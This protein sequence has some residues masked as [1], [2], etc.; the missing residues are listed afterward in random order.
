MSSLRQAIRALRASPF[1]STMVI[2]SLA[3]GIGANVA[4]FSIVDA[5]ILRDLPV[6]HAGRLAML[7]DDVGGAGF[8]SH[9]IWESIQRRPYLFDGAFA[10][11]GVKFNLAERGAVDGVDGLWAS[12]A[13]FEVLGVDAVAG[14]TF[15]EA[16]DRIGGGP[17]GP[18]AVLSYDFWQ[19]RFAGNPAVIGQTIHLDRA[20]FTVIGVTGPRFFGPEIGRTFDVAVPLNTE[21]LVRQQRSNLGARGSFWLQVVVRLKPGQTPE[22]ATAAFRAVQPEIAEETRPENVRPEDAVRHFANPM[23]VRP[24]TTVS[25]IRDQYDEPLLALTAIVAL[26][27]LIACGNIANLLLARA[28]A[29]QHEYSVRS[30]LGAKATTLGRQVLAESA[31][32]AAIGAAAGIVLAVLGSRFL[33]AQISATTNRVFNRVFLD[34]GV[35]WRMLA[36]TG[37]VAVLTTLIFGVGPA[38]RSSRV[39]PMDALR[40]HGRTTSGRTGVANSLVSMQ[41]ALSLVLLV[42][43][44]LFVRSFITLANKELGFSPDNVLVVELGTART[45]TDSAARLVMYQRM[46]NAVRELPGVSQAAMS[47]I[48]P[49]SGSNSTRVMSFPGRPELPERERRVWMNV[50]TRDWFNTVGMPLAAGRAF[51]ERDHIGSGR[52]VVVNEA[53]VRKFF[54]G[55]SPIGM[56]IVEQPTSYADPRPMEIIG[57]VRDAVY[58]SL[59]EPVPPTMYWSME[60]MIR[61]PG[62][63]F[64]MARATG[65]AVVSARIQAA[66]LD[67]NQDVTTVARPFVDVVDAA[68]SRERLVARL[69]SFFGLLALLLAALGLYGTTSYAVTR[70]HTELG[71]RMA[72]GTAPRQI[73]TL[74]LSSVAR[75]LVIGLVAGGVV[76]WWASRFIESM[77]YELDAHDLPTRVGAAMVLAVVALLA[78]WLPARR[79]ARIDPAQ[80]LRDA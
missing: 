49:L 71:I 31:L 2:L 79:A 9:P 66:I 38:L 33:V 67:V 17:D 40:D 28:T 45:G 19:R 4:M 54:A 16:D 27:L 44:G 36:F 34:V 76:A 5:L 58:R 14:R 52:S 23:T 53:F 69:S 62:V 20:A 48:T 32:L 72:L 24:G 74:V 26:T 61:P 42:S 29:R 65:T 47:S 78:G 43:A 59:R 15:N 35:D 21:P 10:Y 7:F 75:L 60:Q 57:V 37:V 22:Q 73:A 30:A 80:V 55:T 39:A 6:R 41:V 63:V 50:V 12:G 18:V 8:W 25:G 64:M 13:M 68:L 51:D 77:L 1:V 70:R 56:S 11:G 46:V 3:L